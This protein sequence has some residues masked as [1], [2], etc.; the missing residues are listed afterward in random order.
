MKITQKNLPTIPTAD[1]V[2][3]INGG[4]TLV[5]AAA[6]LISTLFDKI[7]EAIAKLGN[8][9]NSPAGRLKRIEALEAQNKL[10]KE[11]NKVLEERLAALEAKG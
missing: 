8:K 11:V 9:A 3:I 7:S 4:I 10:Q 6:P 2:G 5:D 1:I